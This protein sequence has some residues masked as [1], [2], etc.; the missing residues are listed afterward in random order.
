L[1]TTGIDPI[2]H[3]WGGIR[4]VA[5]D[6][7]KT[8]LQQRPVVIG[9][10]RGGASMTT[11]N[12]EARRAQLKST[13]EAYFAGLAK[14]DVSSVPWHDDILLR[15]PLAP[16]SPDVPLRGKPAV[17]QWFEALFPVLGETR[18][19]EHYFNEGLTVIATRADVGIT[20]PPC[21]LRVVDRFTVNAAG[22]ITQQE[23]HY[24]PRPAIHPPS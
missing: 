16:E 10:K 13:S 14:R 23:N 24:D 3:S 9:S 12:D 7:Q 15:S 5:G 6:A 19:I 8:V 18:V 17:I 22:Q 1:T 4:D 11:T 2:I 21:F 20:E